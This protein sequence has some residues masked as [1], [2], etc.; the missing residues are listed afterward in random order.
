MGIINR[1]LLFVFSIG[2]AALSVLTLLLAS[3]AVPELIWLNEVQ[4]ILARP[5][6]IASSIIVLVLS[7]WLL[8][9]SL[10]S[11]AE[12][13][14][15]SGGFILLQ[16]ENGGV[17]VALSAVR[18]MVEQ[19]LM[20]MRG[21][22]LAKVRAMGVKPSGKAPETLRLVLELTVSRNANVKELTDAATAAVRAE[23]HD[24]M[25][26]D[27]VAVD[28]KITSIMNALPEKRHVV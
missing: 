5:E 24:V 15:R 16:T 27:D 19:T 7:L 8:R 25:G 17:E 9:M 1:F 11:N 2:T 3:K 20:G 13:T 28:T 12:H 18:N 14:R 23:I 4:Y 22:R 21:I 6:T 10:Y 26:L